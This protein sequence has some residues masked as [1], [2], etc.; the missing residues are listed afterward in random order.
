MMFSLGACLILF[1]QIV[2][3]VLFGLLVFAALAWFLFK[4]WL[5]RK[6]QGLGRATALFDADEPMP[7]R[8]HLQ[9]SELDA[10][11]ESLLSAWGEAHA[12]GFRLLADLETRE[13]WPAHVR[14]AVHSAS[15]IGLCL[16]QQEDEVHY[17]LFALGEGQ[18]LWVRSDGPGESLRRGALDWTV[19]PG[20]PLAAAFAALAEYGAGQDL[21]PLDLPLLRRVF[22]RSHAQREDVLLA[23]P[24]R[25]EAIERRAS[26]LGGKFTPEDIELAYRVTRDQWLSRVREAVLDHYLQVSGVSALDWQSLEPRLQVVCAGMESSELRDILVEDERDAALFD[27]YAAQGL[28]PFALYEAVAARRPAARQMRRLRELSL[29]LRARLY[30]PVE[31]VEEA[32]AP[33]RVHLLRGTSPEG[34]DVE[35]A[36]MA[37]NGGEA[38]ALAGGAGLSAVQVLSEPAPMSDLGLEFLEP[39]AARAAVRGLREPFWL[40]LLRSL[41]SNVYLWGPPVA[42]SAWN[43]SQGQP[44]GWGDYLG[45]LYLG[46]ALL[47]MLFVIG[48]MVAYNGLMRARLHK[49]LRTARLCL[50]LLSRLSLFGGLSRDQLL[51]E[52][53]RLDADAGMGERALTAWEAQASR[54]DLPTQLAGRVQL[55]SAV[56]RLDEML[57]TQRQAL[58]AAPG[59]M[60]RIDLAMS[61]AKHPQHA[62]EAA[63]LIEDVQP[64]TLSELVALG[65]GFTRGLLAQHAGRDAEALQH[66]ASALSQA[67][68]YRGIPMVQALVAEIQGWSVLS[69]RRCGEVERARALWQTVAPFLSLH[70]ACRPLLEREAA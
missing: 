46:L 3:G 19:S 33:A 39:E 66:F 65:Y 52:R 26:A 64:Q 22:E 32:E 68:S 47:G 14:A 44:F 35:H 45:F 70:P 8:L 41:K 7:A 59:E 13:G 2:V 24:P 62:D 60:A 27:Q 34:A 31:R 43:L 37:R 16:C 61:L 58:E 12:L 9:L 55:L 63:R 20:E 50:W 6:L 69:L 15:G 56:G 48:P 53:L 57:Q 11:A 1:L 17:R 21:R 23:Q 5:R 10:P 29:P 18:R 49:R 4:F 51:L 42:I 67:E 30:G 38:R 54:R 40:T 28:D 25:R 36:V